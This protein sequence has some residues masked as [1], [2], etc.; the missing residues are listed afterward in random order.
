VYNKTYNKEGKMPNFDKMIP[1]ISYEQIKNTKL[2]E[3][4]EHIVNF[5]S[6]D[7]K[8]KISFIEVGTGS[9]DFAAEIVES[10]IIDKAII[11]DT[12]D[13]YEDVHDRHA[14][15]EQESFVRERFSPYPNIR[16][17]K[18]DSKNT[19][20]EICSSETDKY[21]FIYLDA[22]H[23]MEQVSSDLDS[24]TK[25]IKETGIIGIDDF[26][27]HPG[28]IKENTGKYQ[29]QEAVSQFLKNNPNWKI[30]YFSFNVGG[31]QNVFLS[32]CW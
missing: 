11:L 23:S 21:D 25:L 31:F 32:Q 24:A 26:C 19:L 20:P 18:G 28:Y 29:A 15:H 5:I 6:E 2:I 12:F 4:R 9:G 3:Q 1:V 7:S 14:A 17:I 10:L 30:K 27:F 22:D 16:I 8:S 13:G